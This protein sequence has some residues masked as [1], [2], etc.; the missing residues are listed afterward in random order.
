MVRVL[1]LTYDGLT[2]PLG[3]SQILP[4]LTKLAGSHTIHIVSFE[5]TCS[6]EK[7]ASLRSELSSVGLGWTPLLYHKKPPVLSTVWD[8]AQ[9]EYW[10]RRLWPRLK[11]QIVHCRSYITAIAGHHL[12]RK[13]RFLFDMRGFYADERRES[14]MWPYGHPVYDMVYNFFKG[15]EKV[16][17][18]E[19]AHVVSLTY[20][21]ALEI[22]K[23]F[24]LPQDKISV[25]PC[26]AD[27]EFFSQCSEE[28]GRKARQRLHIPDSSSVLIYVG[29]LGTWYMPKE[30][31]DFFARYRLRNPN[32]IFLV[33]NRGEHEVVWRAAR[34]AGLA[35][36]CIRV[37]AAERSEMPSLLK[38]A[39]AG[40]FFV[41]PTYSKLASS[42]VKMG[43][44]LAAGLPVIT[45]SG[46]GDVDTI[47]TQTN[48]GI[49]VKGFSVNDYEAA[50]DRWQQDYT[51]YRNNALKAA[52]KFFD[53]EDGVKRYETIY[54][55]LGEG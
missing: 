53:L 39:N 31:M 27:V 25:I 55:L 4:Y 51:T 22:Q 9:L 47:V 5:K 35:P 28:E 24:G 33:V 12:R 44:M 42:P 17:L 38:A 2:D 23:K 3:Q 45:N 20:A 16:W 41:R 8:I 36:E 13:A 19:A 14:G 49:L 43:E 6:E 40:L 15:R 34:M 48:C 54:R 37:L 7:L 50:L 30:M 32:S 10:C 1:Y 11:P 18:S 52:K 26:A 46:V 21:G 29:S